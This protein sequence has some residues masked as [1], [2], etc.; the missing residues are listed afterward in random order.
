MLDFMKSQAEI[1][2]AWADE[3]RERDLGVFRPLQDQYIADAQEW[4]SPTRMNARAN[5]AGADVTLAAA[6]GKAARARDYASMGIDPRSG[7]AADATARADTA[8]ALGTAG[9]RN[10]ARRTVRNEAEGRRA[11]AINLGAGLGVNPGTSMGLSN[12]AV[13]AGGNAAMQGY[14]QQA[15]IL[16]QDY[17]NRYNSWADSTSSL[18]GAAGTVAGMVPWAS[19]F[20][21]KELKHDKAP[22]RGVLEAVE[23]LD[24]D[25]WRYKDGVA[26][27]GERRHI[28]P[29][30]EDVQAQTGMG[31]GKTLQLA[32]MT[33]MALGAIKELSQ[34]VTDLEA[35]VAP[36][37]VM[38]EAA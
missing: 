12:G 17:Q 18:F 28:G 7:R 16:N 19:V 1:T 22:A 6:Q 38:M 23:G 35:K 15:G 31:D 21:S 4:D 24:V 2:N 36:R 25:T 32:D 3:D 5:E 34:K 13:Q 8:T 9:A 14:N 33:G 20:S 37:G 10:L 30:A 27:G 26:D 11:N 29:Y